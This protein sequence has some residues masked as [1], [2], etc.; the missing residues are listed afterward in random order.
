MRPRLNAE[1][2]AWAWIAHVQCKK[3]GDGEGEKE[4]EKRRDE[5]AAEMERR[6]GIV[7]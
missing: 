4:T 7:K 6:G 3:N 2:R 1:N 5:H